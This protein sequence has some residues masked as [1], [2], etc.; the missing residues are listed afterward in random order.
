MLHTGNIFVRQIE[1][2][3]ER[4]ELTSESTSSVHVEAL[5]MTLP[6]GRN[7][8]KE[9]GMKYETVRRNKT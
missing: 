1:C 7:R 6:G 8:I 3:G 2:Q 5:G 9:D 4:V